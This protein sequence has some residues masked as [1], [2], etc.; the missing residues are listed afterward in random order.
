M[1]LFSA[2]CA[3]DHFIS[4]LWTG[5]LI[6]KLGLSSNT[7]TSGD[8]TFLALVQTFPLRFVEVN[9]ISLDKHVTMADSTGHRLWHM[10]MQ[11]CS[12]GPLRVISN[13]WREFCY[14]HSLKKNDALVFTLLSFSHFVVEFG[15]SESTRTTR[16]MYPTRE[17]GKY[18]WITNGPRIECLSWRPSSENSHH[19]VSRPESDT[20]LSVPAS[21]LRI[22]DTN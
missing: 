14:D 15:S 1:E 17:E 6:S 22:R 7:W 18:P 9:Y 20:L 21:P 16:S 2:V 8:F 5:L 3:H 12:K 11:E 13:G 19:K 4:N 10:R